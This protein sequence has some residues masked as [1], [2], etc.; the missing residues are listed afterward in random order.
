MRKSFS[1]PAIVTR[2]TGRRPP[3]P[4]VAQPAA[5]PVV[6][7]PAAE[8][9]EPFLARAVPLR[10]AAMQQAEQAQS[11]Q[12]AARAAAEWCDLGLLTGDWR[13]V[14]TTAA[15]GETWLE[16]EDNP[17]VRVY[18]HTRLATAHHRLGALPESL[19]IFQEAEQWQAERKTGYHWLIGLPGKAYC[20]LLLEQARTVSEWEWVL[21]RSQY[22]QKIV[23]NQ[24]ALA[25]DLQTQGR[26]LAALGQQEMARATFQQ[27]VV[28]LRKS[29]KRLFLP[30][31]LLHQ[32]LF[33]R[34]QGEAL[35]TVRLLLAEALQ[36]AM[37]EGLRPAEVDGRLLEGHVW[38]DEGKT[39][40]AEQA[41][42]GAE[43][44]LAGL[45][46]GQRL[47]EVQVLRARLLQ[48]QG[49]PGAARDGWA[50]AR[51]RVAAQGQWGVMAVWE[52]EMVGFACVSPGALPL[53]PTLPYAHIFC[54][55]PGTV[56]IP[57]GGVGGKSPT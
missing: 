26:A 23:K 41:L 30:E 51:Q 31:L 7:Q 27:A 2:L 19:A 9:P 11:W 5:P 16:R 6:A 49:D 24:F 56:T 44:V 40:E 20:D 8:P 46:Y 47:V 32:A 43:T 36:M 52:R 35:P 37:A 38:L 28:T 48:Q 25:L 55:G 22:S 53:D 14:L 50:V 15:Q 39:E 12:A 54:R 13:T 29:N 57:G 34:H 45:E 21:H 10:W 4:V 17:L 3:P 33:L 18:L 1:L 42:R